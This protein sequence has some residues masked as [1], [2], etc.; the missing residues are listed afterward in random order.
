[1]FPYN[2]T[3]FFFYLNLYFKLIFLDTCL[4]LEYNLNSRDISYYLNLRCHCQ[5]VVRGEI[6]AFSRQ[7]WCKS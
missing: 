7:A 5:S 2:L 3:H 4:L 1:M 6:A